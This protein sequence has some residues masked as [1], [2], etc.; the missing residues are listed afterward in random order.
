MQILR[1]FGNKSPDFISFTHAAYLTKQR[2][3]K[4]H[5]AAARC[6]RYTFYARRDLPV[7]TNG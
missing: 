6:T 1:S 5:K 2:R 4:A 3:K 7:A